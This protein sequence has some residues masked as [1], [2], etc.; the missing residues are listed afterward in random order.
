MGINSIFMNLINS[1][2]INLRD[3]R[4]VSF[5]LLTL[6]STFGSCSK[7]KNQIDVLII[8]LNTNQRTTLKSIARIREEAA[9]PR[10]AKEA[11]EL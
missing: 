3:L 6:T 4:F 9:N 7:K 1:A 8:F 10:E 5:E 2:W 11:Q